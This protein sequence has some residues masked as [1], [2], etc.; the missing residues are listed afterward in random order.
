MKDNVTMNLLNYAELIGLNP[1]QVA[2]TNGGEYASACP[3]CGGDD[4][5]RMWPNQKQNKCI[6]RYWCR[7]CNTNGDTIEFLMKFCDRTFK[8]AYKESG[9]EQ[10]NKKGYFYQTRTVKKEAKLTSIQAA[11]QKWKLMAQ[12]FVDWA[13]A[14]IRYQPD[15]LSYLAQRGITKEVVDRFKIGYNPKDM[16]RNPEEWG[17][18]A[19]KKIF[20][21]KGIVIPV[22][23]IDEIVRITVRRIDWHEQDTYGK[24]VNVRGSMNGLNIIGDKKQPAMI[25]VESLLD[26]FVVAHVL[27][28]KAFA[29][30]IGGS[31]K[32]PDYCTD[33][34]AQNKRLIICHDNDETGVKVFDDWKKRYSHAE[35]VPVPIDL[36]KDIGEAIENGLGLRTWLLNI[37]DDENID[38]NDSEPKIIKAE[39][40]RDDQNTMFSEVNNIRYM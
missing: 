27:S 17:L 21:A 22:F 35:A 31:I 14:N 32:N 8:E 38:S 19:G 29:V 23:D 1:K 24:Y 18:D 4:R 10:E 36:G 6:G 3:E 26:A 33:H 34:F 37:I 25:C 20:L 39:S 11:P 40:D 9:I 5:F 28:D 13:Y 30:A 2:S 7:Q 15:I 16:W 12:A